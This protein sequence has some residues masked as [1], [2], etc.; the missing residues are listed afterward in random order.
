SEV[1]LFSGPP[2]LNGATLHTVLSV[3][4]D[5]TEAGYVAGLS[6]RFGAS[7]LLKTLRAGLAGGGAP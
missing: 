3:L 7:M 5:M 6:L 1:Q 4:A 2:L